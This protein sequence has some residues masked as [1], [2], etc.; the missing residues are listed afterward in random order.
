MIVDSLWQ[1]GK[2]E[3]VLDVNSENYQALALY[4]K[5]GFKVEVAY[6]Y[7]RLKIVVTTHLA[8]VD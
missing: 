4:K 7:Y 1:K 6:E 2:T 3:V 8:D 5:F